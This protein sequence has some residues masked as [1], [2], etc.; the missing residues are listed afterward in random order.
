MKKQKRVFLEFQVGYLSNQGLIVS[1]AATKQKKKGLLRKR[2][3]II[4]KKKG[5]YFEMFIQSITSIVP[6]FEFRSF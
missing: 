5:K 2:R 3:Y 6:L 4:Q 1:A